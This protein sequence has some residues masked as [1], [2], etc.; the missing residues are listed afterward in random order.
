MIQFTTSKGEYVALPISKN[1][2]AFRIV[3]PIED[4][5]NQELYYIRGND[6]AKVMIELPQ[7]SWSFLCTTDDISEEVAAGIVDEEQGEQIYFDYNRKSYVLLSGE[8]SFITLLQSL[9]LSP[10]KNYA[11][12]KK[13]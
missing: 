6:A 8:L 12:C 1:A 13:I 5:T 2:S 10:D 3:E 9:N 7:G 4:D 11:I